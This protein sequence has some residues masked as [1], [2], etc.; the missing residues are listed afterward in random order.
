MGR[1]ALPPAIAG[2][3]AIIIVGVVHGRERA[4]V[5]ATRVAKHF[6]FVVLGRNVVKE[7]KTEGGR[8]DETNDCL[9]HVDYLS[10]RAQSRANALEALEGMSS[11]SNAAAGDHVEGEAKRDRGH[12]AGH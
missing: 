8:D 9:N 1:V 4:A 3:V 12:E 6:A 11:R 7:P 2:Q 5:G 10:N